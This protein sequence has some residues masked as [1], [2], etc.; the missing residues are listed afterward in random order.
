MLLLY[1]S[2]LVVDGFFILLTELSIVKQN[3]LGKVL[4]LFKK[5]ISFTYSF[6][7]AIG[8]EYAPLTATA[9]PTPGAGPRAYEQTIVCSTLTFRK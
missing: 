2:L 3:D 4:I 6:L 5:Y 7:S 8:A 1:A 9:K